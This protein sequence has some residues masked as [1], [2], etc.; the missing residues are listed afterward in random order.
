M[1]LMSTWGCHLCEEAQSLLRQAGVLPQC[2]V[3][4]IVDQPE[5]FE[6]Y[7]IHIPVLVDG[8]RELFWPFELADVQAFA[9]TNK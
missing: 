6:R 1:Q 4:D 2:E 9:R 7:R 3:V 8:S 5:L